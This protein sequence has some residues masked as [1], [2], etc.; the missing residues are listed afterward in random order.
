MRTNSV[1]RK[2]VGGKQAAGDSAVASRGAPWLLRGFDRTQ[3]HPLN[4][5]EIDSLVK[6]GTPGRY[7]LGY[8]DARGAFRVQYVG[9]TPHD[10]NGELKSR[11]GKSRYFKFRVGPLAAPRVAH[12]LHS[13]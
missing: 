12:P 9:Y 8:R 6:R 3:T 4:A 10:L 2:N 7:A 5:E 13:R 1:G 11:I